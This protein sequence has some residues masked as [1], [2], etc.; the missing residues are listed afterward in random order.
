MNIHDASTL[1]HSKFALV[2]FIIHFFSPNKSF[3]CY[4]LKNSKEKISVQ[5]H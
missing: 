2:I 5:T 1:L 3:Y 4:A